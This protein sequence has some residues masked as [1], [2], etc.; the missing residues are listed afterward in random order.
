MAE[1]WH[2]LIV[3]SARQVREVLHQILLGAGYKCL[4]ANDGRAG[5]EAFRQSRPPLVI[6]QLNLPHHLPFSGVFAGIELLKQV[7]RED[8]DVAVI[9]VSDSPRRETAAECLKFGADAYIML[10]LNV[11]ELLTAAERALRARHKYPTVRGQ[12]QVGV[13]RDRIL[14]DGQGQ[15]IKV[16]SIA[17]AETFVKYFENHSE[18]DALFI[19]EA[20]VG[21]EVVAL[22]RTQPLT[23]E[24]I[25][26]VRRLMVDIDRIA[27]YNG[28][29]WYAFRG[30]VDAWLVLNGYSALPA[31][32][33]PP[34]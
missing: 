27:H 18:D 2:L 12:N 14:A 1:Q 32:G 25:E 3:H 22:M 24:A 16:G 17:Y 8:P 30:S 21:N 34:G 4:L 20:T 26:E 13:S 7:R 33:T 29:G 31:P 19:P 11:D 9:V 23:R 5:L 28:T 10:P 6:T 15:K